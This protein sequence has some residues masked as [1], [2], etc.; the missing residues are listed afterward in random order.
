MMTKSFRLPWHKR[1]LKHPVFQDVV[2]WLIAVVM[3][4]CW[5]SYRI[6]KQ[7]H[8]DSIPYLQGTHNGIFCFWHGRMILFPFFKP[9][10]R[11]MHVLISFHRD[12]ELIAKVIRH[13]SI[14]T[15]RGSSNK[16]ARA[17]TRQLLEQ[18]KKGDNISITPDGPRGPVFQAEKG[19]ILLAKL[20][21]K[22]LIPVSFSASRSCQLSSW[23]RFMI[24][25]P[26]SKLF[27]I[28]DAP[29]MIDSKADESQRL[30]LETR[31]NQ[32]T[33]QADMA[34]KA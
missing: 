20:A 34:M 19:A 1:V 14:R 23:D 3:K 12:G 18:L 24:P 9:K 15:I 28:A 5:F 26:F 31:L 16:G 17:A 27:I 11:A 30:E 32:I 6:E 4:L 29:L 21:A 13:F 8:P 25:L 33:N 10:S 2:T 7:I 22:P